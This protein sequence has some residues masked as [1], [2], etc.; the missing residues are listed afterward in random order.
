MEF[1]DR[2][3]ALISRHMIVFTLS[4][5]ALGIL[6]PDTFS[7]LLAFTPFFFAILTFSSSL[8]AGFRELR[9][10]LLRPRPIL[11]ILLIL[12]VVVPV[13]TLLIGSAVFPNDPLFVTGMVLQNCLPTGVV[14]LM[15]VTIGR[16]STPLSLATVLLDTL[17]APFLIPLSLRLLLGSVVEMDTL[18]MMRQLL[19]MIALPALAAMTWNH[20]THGR[21]AQTVQPRL[22]VVSKL[23]MVL[24]ILANST[25]IASYIRGMTFHLFRVMLFAT[26]IVVVSFAVS[27]LLARAQKFDYPVCVSVTLNASIRN[28]NAGAVLATQFFPPDVL[29]PVVTSTLF[30]HALAACALRLLERMQANRAVQSVPP[31]PEA[32]PEEQ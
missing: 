29:F 9:A 17:L 12:H 2:L 7:P 16:G 22:A 13:L 20:V 10:V 24:V 18:S 1:L 15:W 30:I 3:D 14:T 5:T 4:F 28:T 31:E 11:T 23:M 8:G 27:Y 19:L 6:F 26:G 25:G 32:A 21:V